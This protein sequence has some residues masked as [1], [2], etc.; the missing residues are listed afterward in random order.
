MAVAEATHADSE[1][2]DLVVEA[3]FSGT[4]SIR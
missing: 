4:F 2:L 3:C 1:Q